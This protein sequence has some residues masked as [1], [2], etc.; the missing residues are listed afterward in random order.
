[1][2]KNAEYY[3]NKYKQLI[4]YKG[5]DEEVLWKKAREKA[6][7]TSKNVDIESL[8]TNKKESKM[9]HDLM[10]KYTEDYNIE[11]QS[12]KNLLKQLIF[13]EVN[14]TRLQE[15]M[16]DAFKSGRKISSQMEDMIIKNSNQV[17]TLKEKLGLNKDQQDA[18][19]SFKALS[20]L[21]KKAAKWREN[22]QGSRTAVCPYCGQMV[23]FKIRT[24]KWE[25]SKHPFFKDRILTNKHLLKLYQEGKIDK[26]D[27][28]KILD[29]SEDYI[30]WILS[31]RKPV[32]V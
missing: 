15:K 7:E 32:E 10:K 18:G 6:I 17:L 12:D 25:V 22:N 30:D 24:D 29:C 3:F 21:E 4:Q 13:F 9:A 11:T 5:V 2:D 8:F 1:M 23:M 27:I 20:L 26:I 28:C 19:D 16:N 14:Q 31:K